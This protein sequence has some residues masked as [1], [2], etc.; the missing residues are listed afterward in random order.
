MAGTSQVPPRTGASS[1]PGPRSAVP[2]RECP[3][4]HGALM[5]R[6]REKGFLCVGDGISTLEH[7]GAHAGHR[8]ACWDALFSWL[9]PGGQPAQGKPGQAPPICG[10]VGLLQPGGFPAFKWASDSHSR[11]TPH[12]LEK[13]GEEGLLRP[14]QGQEGRQESLLIAILTQPPGPA[15]G[16]ECVSQPPPPPSS[17]EAWRR[18]GD[19][20]EAG[21]KL[22]ILEGRSA[23]CLHLPAALRR[24]RTPAWGR[25]GACGNPGSEQLISQI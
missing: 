5:P 15:L 7:P 6:D 4:C 8:T 25:R 16:T 14:W 9:S 18:E 2:S 22:P 13:T 24:N 12:T 10:A 1:G 3:L 19:R 17:E 23:S 21:P 20:C 11:S